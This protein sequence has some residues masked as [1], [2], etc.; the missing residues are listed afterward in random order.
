MT[1]QST[2]HFGGEWEATL[3]SFAKTLENLN[4]NVATFGRRIESLE[5]EVLE[6]RLS[7]SK[8]RMTGGRR[9]YPDSPYPGSAY[10]GSLTK[11]ED[12]RG[13]YVQDSMEK[14]YRERK[15]MGMRPTE[16]NT[17]DKSSTDLKVPRRDG[18]SNSKPLDLTNTLPTFDGITGETIFRIWHKSFMSCDALWIFRFGEVVD[19]AQVPFAGHYQVDRDVGS[20]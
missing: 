13:A 18:E 5:T 20:R 4:E 17:S 12:D 3:A 11:D 9:M 1:D 7:K 16:E 15:A 10:P 19:L 8:K 6:T 2:S 14:R